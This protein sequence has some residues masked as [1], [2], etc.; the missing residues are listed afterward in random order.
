MW[1]K[2]PLEIYIFNKFAECVR[3][4]IT[5]EWQL[6]TIE[7]ELR[8]TFKVSSIP[9]S[10]AAILMTLTLDSP[11]PPSRAIVMVAGG[12]TLIDA[13]VYTLHSWHCHWDHVCV[14]STAHHLLSAYGVE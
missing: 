8:N 14:F 3:V 2:Y 6:F 1:E 12:D 13:V 11:V 7:N 5:I 9:R 4:I 10:S